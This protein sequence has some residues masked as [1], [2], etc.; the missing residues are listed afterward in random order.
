MV[1][2]LKVGLLLDGTGVP[3]WATKAI[4]K[5]E[6]SGHAQIVMVV[7]NKASELN[8]SR[9]AFLYRMHEWFDHARNDTESNPFWCIS[10]PAVL[11][12]TTRLEIDRR[13]DSAQGLPEVVVTKF[14]ELDLDVLI[15]LC[16]EY[17]ADHLCHCCRYGVLSFHCGDGERYDGIPPGFWEIFDGAPI[18]SSHIRW[19]VDGTTEILCR[20]HSSTIARSERLNRE[21]VY[22]KGISFLSRAIEC[23]YQK[24]V[25]A[26]GPS[27]SAKL[28]LHALEHRGYPG[29]VDMMRFFLR[30]FSADMAHKA[31]RFF[32]EGRWGVRYKLGDE[33]PY[34]FDSFTSLITPRHMWWADPIVARQDDDRLIFIESL[35]LPRSRNH[36][37]ISVIRVDQD[38]KAFE[39]VKVL[40]R[41]YHL[42]YPFVFEWKGTH[43]MIPESSEAGTI[44]LYQADDFPYGWKHVKDIMT[45]ISAHDNTLLMRDGR[46][47]LF[48]NMMVNRNAPVD[49][50]LFIFHSD[51]L[52]ADSWEPHPMNPVVS[53]ARTARP[54]GPF[55]EEGGV[56]YRPSQDCSRC[57]GYAININ[58]VIELNE[59]RYREER[60][61]Y[62]NPGQLPQA[63]RVHTFSHQFGL[64]AIDTY[65]AIPRMLPH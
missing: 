5:M 44:E 24:S 3:Y 9:D 61:R 23:I 4:E 56:L 49:D 40:E 8:L 18:T 55:F 36:A 27:E 64:T 14:K 63:S 42:S 37:Y 17:S 54:A 11:D 29:N 52:F 60:V 1:Q 53:D 26:Y 34:S 31:S 15:D 30:R 62:I 48:C 25:G 13:V 32:T 47:W 38:G 2:R 33:V 7:I 43:Y 12:C 50:E 51:D 22:N 57:Y 19:A 39:P 45:G 6:V 21:Q 41:P 59:M 20:S 35:V 58:K 10:L 65:T 46:W 16:G 28:D